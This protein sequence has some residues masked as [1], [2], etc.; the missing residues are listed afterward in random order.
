M[1]VAAAAQLA[2]QSW[3]GS[4]RF[5]ADPRNPYVY[6]HTGTD[7]FPIVERLKDLA[8]AHPDGSSMP[9]QIISPENLWPLP[10]YLRGLSGIGWWNGVSDEAE[11]APVIVVTPE[12]EPALVRKLY[13]LPP[14]RGAGAVH[15]HLRGAGRAAPAGRAARLRGEDPLGRLPPPR[16][17][18]AR[19]F[20][21]R[22]PA[23]KP[24]EPA[25]AGLGLGEAT[26]G[27]DAH[28]FAHEAMATVFEVVCAHDDAGY[29]RQAAQAAFDL[30]DRLEREL[31]RFIANSDVSRVNALAA[32]RAT[33]VSP[34]TM[35]CLEIARRMHALT[36][37]AFDISIGSGL[38]RLD[39]VP[40]DF[41]VRAP[42]GRGPAGPGRHRQGL[43]GRPHGGASGRVGDPPGPPSRGLQL[44]PRP[45]RR[46]RV[47]TGG[48]SP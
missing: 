27:L 1:L 11:S 5:P 4:F 30:V 26:A 24:E 14:A 36:G 48:P 28:R 19:A 13:D 8:R 10:W 15:E 34:E 38:E 12:M 18:S 23:M 3:S 47:A 21:A 32:G 31:S 2:W 41:V 25:G 42:G 44:G 37:G 33:R 20:L 40:D 46:P 7:V 39:L 22:T 43:R 35:E 9:L 45:G 6:A 16:G 17:R 29:A